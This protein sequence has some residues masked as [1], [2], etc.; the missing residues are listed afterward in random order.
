[1]AGCTAT[2][3]QQTAMH[4]RTMAGCTATTN[5]QV[6]MHMW[7]VCV[8]VCEQRIVCQQ[9]AEVLGLGISTIDS[10]HPPPP[11]HI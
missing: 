9:V 8:C 4:K 10:N 3:N 5:Q 1:M 2:T 6:T 7:P 11:P